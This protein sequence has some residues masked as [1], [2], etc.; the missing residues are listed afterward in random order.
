MFDAETSNLKYI[1]MNIPRKKNLK[2]NV[3]IQKI[4]SY[5]PNK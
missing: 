5:T 3:E 4:K 2:Q 1:P